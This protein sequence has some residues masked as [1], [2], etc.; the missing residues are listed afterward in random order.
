VAQALLS[1]AA[2]DSAAVCGDYVLAVAG[3][4]RLA[5]QEE[6]GDAQVLAGTLLLSDRTGK[7]FAA[8]LQH[9][10]GPGQADALE[11]GR[12]ALRQA[13]DKTVVQLF[14][15][16]PEAG[17]ILRWQQE[18]RHWAACGSSALRIVDAATGVRGTLGKL[19][20]GLSFSA[21]RPVVYRKKAALM[22]VAEAR[23]SLRPELDELAPGT[24]PPLPVL[25][26][27]V[28]RMVDAETGKV[29]A[30]SYVLA[31]K[32]VRAPARQMAQWP[33]WRSAAEPWFKLLGQGITQIDQLDMAAAVPARR[34][35]AGQACTTVFLLQGLQD[36]W[37]ETARKALAQLAGRSVRPGRPVPSPVLLEGVGKLL[38]LLDAF[39]TEGVAVP[40]LPSPSHVPAAR[41]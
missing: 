25:R 2:A 14:A 20:A 11:P 22:S 18:G 16:V 26:C 15:R 21:A 41:N 27:V 1:R 37:A 3:E 13:L 31:C 34:L 4:T 40:A 19:A 9:L 23:V 28:R 6:G 32:G 29:L 17:L 7:P 12:L 39:E 5:P 33:A 8:P 30:H 10:A 35:I 36:E 24:Q 38:V